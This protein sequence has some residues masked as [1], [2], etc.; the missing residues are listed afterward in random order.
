MGHAAIGLTSLPT[1]RADAFEIALDRS[2]TPGGDA[3]FQSDS[4]RIALSND[5]DRLP[6][7]DGGLG[8]ILSDA[9]TTLE[10]P[11]SSGRPRPTCGY[12]PT[13]Q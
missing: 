13:T 2:A 5:G 4:L 6:D 10:A 1:V 3:L 12:S 8:Y 7:G 11:P 9:E